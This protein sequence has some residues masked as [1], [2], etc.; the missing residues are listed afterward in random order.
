[1]SSNGIPG[2]D[3]TWCLNSILQAVDLGYFIDLEMLFTTMIA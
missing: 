2:G 1:M 3:T